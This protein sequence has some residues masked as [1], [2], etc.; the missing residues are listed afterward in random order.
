MANVNKVKVNNTVYDIE[1]TV[2]RSSTVTMSSRADG[3]VSL[4]SASAGTSVN[5]PSLTNFGD[6]GLLENDAVT[7][8]NDLK[9]QINRGGLTEELKYAFWEFASHVGA[10]TDG[11]AQTYLDDLYD[12]LYPPT[13]LS[14][15]T[16][17]YTQETAVYVDTPLNDLKTDLVVTAHYDDLTT[18][19][20]TA[21]ALSGTL[22]VGDSVITV[23]YSGKTT[24]FTV[25]VSKKYQYVEYIENDGDADSYIELNVVPSN[26]FGFK[27]TV[28]ITERTEVAYIFGTQEVTDLRMLLAIGGSNRKPYFGWGASTSSYANVNEITWGTPF[29]A[30][31]N[32]KNS[33]TGEINGD[34]AFNTELEALRYTPTWKFL[35]MGTRTS[36]GYLG[37][38]QKLYSLEITDGNSVVMDLKPCYRTADNAIG[39][40]DEI[41]DVFYGNTGT[42]TLKKGAD[43]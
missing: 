42:G 16:A 14:Y 31:L 11:N 6:P 39:L 24:T 13:N 37:R 8:I 18:E 7:E 5:V 22:S 28:S 20:V 2:A 35:A 10:F 9:S 33:R 29:T 12:A 26:T 25:T 41:N 38:Q 15:I 4:S 40:Y 19:T 21:Y 3:S 34:S 23:T 43:I 27:A 30:S 17:E 1:D 36:N 32:Y